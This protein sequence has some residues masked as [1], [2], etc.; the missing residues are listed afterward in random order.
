MSEDD[1]HNARRD[2][3]PPRQMPAPLQSPR[4]SVPRWVGIVVFVVLIGASLSVGGYAL[5]WLRV[6][7]GPPPAPEAVTAKPS[8]ERIVEPFI[9]SASADHFIFRD[10][11]APVP[12]LA[13]F[14]SSGRSLSLSDFR[15]RPIVLNIWA[16]WCVPCRREMPSLDWLQG[17]FDPAKLL[18]LAL[19]ADDASD[20]GKFYE[21]LGLHSL[22]IYISSTGGEIIKLGLPGFPGTLLIDANGNEI[23]RKLGPAEWDRPEIVDLLVQ[24]FDLPAPFADAKGSP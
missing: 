18:V 11:P 7:S 16:K 24:H 23:G 14:D 6:D 15:G 1:D 13:F 8:V 12:D 17:K 10:M 19:S 2:R 22:G 21:E 3:K 9:Y 5:G 20:V 4:R